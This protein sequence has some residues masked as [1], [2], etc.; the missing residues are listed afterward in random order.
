MLI[1]ISGITGTCGQACARAAL[2]A[3]HQVRGLSRTPDKLGGDISERLESFIKLEN[4]Y[5]LEALDRAVVGVDAIIS[6]VAPFPEV[7]L[8][9]QLLLLRAAERAGV[10]VRP[11]MW[12]S[13]SPS[14]HRLLGLPWRDVEL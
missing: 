3:G 1:L 14:A 9:G 11:R 8:E 12:C 7:L 10:K 5:D 4:I 6:A 2:D 13:A